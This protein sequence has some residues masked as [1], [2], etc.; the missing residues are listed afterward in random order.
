MGR[1][2]RAGEHVI[3]IHT[4]D[5]VRFEAD[6]P[7][8]ERMSQV[9]A[10]GLQAVGEGRCYEVSVTDAVRI[11]EVQDAVYERARAQPRTNGPQPMDKPPARPATRGP[12]P[13]TDR[14]RR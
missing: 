7:H 3:E 6:R 4:T 1:Y 11:L 8:S 14:R 13:A 12:L 9:I 10:D 5:G 2:D